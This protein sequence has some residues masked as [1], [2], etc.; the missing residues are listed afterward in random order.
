MDIEMDWRGLEKSCMCDSLTGEQGWGQWHPPSRD[1][2]SPCPVVMPRA[3]HVDYDWVILIDPES[4]RHRLSRRRRDVGWR[5]GGRR[6]MVAQDTLEAITDWQ[7]HISNR[8]DLG[9]LAH[10]DARRTRGQ[11]RGERCKDAR[12][13]K[14]GEPNVT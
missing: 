7:Y 12:L 3:H 6:T 2:I 13:A 4:G 5:G 9:H 11:K 14:Q 1:R 8:R 10:K